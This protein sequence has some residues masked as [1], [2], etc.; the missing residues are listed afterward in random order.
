MRPSLTRRVALAATAVFLAACG[1]GD[2]GGTTNPPAVGG[3][4]V[5][6]SQNTLSVVQGGTT[7]LTANIART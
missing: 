7:T 6:L 3:F 2:D 5:T 1:G 4:T